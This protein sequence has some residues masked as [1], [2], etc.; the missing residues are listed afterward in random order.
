ML[1]PTLPKSYKSSQEVAAPKVSNGDA[2]FWETKTLAE[3]NFEEWE[4]LCDGCGLCCLNKLQDEDTD[5][6]A[7][8]CVVCSYSDVT[9]GR[10][11]DYDNRNT[12]VPTCVQLTAELASEFHWLPTTCAYRLL[13]AGA[14]LPSW[15]PLITGDPKSVQQAKVGLTAIK[16]VVDNGQL[17]Y[18]D[19]LIDAL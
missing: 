15:H 17:D 16:V 11:K 8:T 2:P 7:Y 19:Y 1:K 5:E 10:C 4:S 18:E 3:M 9:T 13:A 6:I 12:N 14:A